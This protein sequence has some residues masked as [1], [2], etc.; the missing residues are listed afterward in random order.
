MLRG[1][2]LKNIHLSMLGGFA[3]KTCIYSCS[4]A[5]TTGYDSLTA[6]IAQSEEK[7]LKSSGKAQVQTLRLTLGGY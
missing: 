1:F 3:L 5:L 4:G 6:N 7:H 2:A